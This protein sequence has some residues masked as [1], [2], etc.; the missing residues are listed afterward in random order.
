MKQKK[1]VVLIHED[2]KL[3]VP[4]KTMCNICDGGFPSKMK[5]DKHIVAIHEDK[6]PYKCSVPIVIFPLHSKGV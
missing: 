4:K 6:K 1:H 5:L 3:Q 2:K